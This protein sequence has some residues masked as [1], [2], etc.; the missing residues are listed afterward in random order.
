LSNRVSS[1]G[2]LVASLAG[3]FLIP[4]LWPLHTAPLPS[5]YSE[6]LAAILLFAAGLSCAVCSWN[7]HNTLRVPAVILPFFTLIIL[8][9]VQLNLGMFT[10]IYSAIFPLLL[11][12]LAMTAVILGS[13]SA[14]RLGLEKLLVWISIAI[15]TGA[16]L[17][18]AIQLAQLY[19]IEAR[20]SRFIAQ[21]AVK[22]T[23]FSANL[24]QTNHLATY[25]ALALVATFYLYVKNFFGVAIV[26]ALTGMLLFALALTGSRMSWLQV[27]C[28]SLIAGY[29]LSKAE[30]QSRPRYWNII[31]LL[32][33]YYLIITL[34][35]PYIGEIANF[36]VKN[37]SVD[38]LQLEAA[39][40]MGRRLIYSQAWDVFIKNPLIGV[41]IGGF[42]FQQYMLLD[43]SDQ[44]LLSDSAHNLILDLLVSV[45]V[46]GA[47][48]F[49]GLLGYWYW[50]A[51]KSAG[52]LE[53][54]VIL[55]MLAVFGIHAMLEY[56][57]WYGYFLWPM[58]FFLGCLE[59][60]FVY[61]RSNA[62]A[63]FFPIIIVSI[64]FISAI[65][66][67]KEYTQIE[68]LYARFDTNVKSESFQAR[69]LKYVDLFNAYSR[70]F[71]NPQ[72]EALVITT[73]PM[74]ES[75]LEAKIEMSTRAIEFNLSTNL[76]FRH[77]ALL[78]MADRQNEAVTH[79][80]R[81]VKLHPE[82]IQ[83]ILID[84][85]RLNSEE[86]EIFGKLLTVLKNKEISQGGIQ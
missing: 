44:I 41:G 37:S 23:N 45:G 21:S 64:G 74:D 46:V 55:L 57:Q 60:K 5:F 15:I 52:T 48:L 9:V 83:M 63:K 85:M 71:F 8:I 84:V 26:L 51:R 42:G 82:H 50:H 43:S 69:N 54:S 47:A 30:S 18:F 20:F 25:L 6:W 28:I 32:P 36:N 53:N 49:V 14:Q 31:F 76:I 86:P 62:T 68:S 10:Y 66:L 70:N 2:L 12:G 78:C 17:S 16:L 58:A 81:L 79:L 72:A 73:L 27:V 40:D 59:T 65:Y 61:L 11:L 22:Q 4:F 39:L 33:L 7:E 24:G 19:G 3:M 67:Y 13:A 1:S 34:A 77:I 38:R 35:L 80:E 29:Y 56:P 75:D